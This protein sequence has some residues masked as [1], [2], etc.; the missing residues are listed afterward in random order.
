MDRPGKVGGL[1][2]GAKDAKVKEPKEPKE[3]TQRSS[4][5][6][7]ETTEISEF[8]QVSHGFTHGFHKMCCQ[9]RE[10]G[11]DLVHLIQVG[12]VGSRIA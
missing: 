2:G 1:G 9:D 10:S 6:S 5:G 11:F 8:L 12:Q 4:E 3:P 7:S